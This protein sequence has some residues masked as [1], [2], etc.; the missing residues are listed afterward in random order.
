MNLFPDDEIARRLSKSTRHLSE[1][2]I[3]EDVEL[4]EM[5]V[6]AVVHGHCHHEA[7]L[8]F[9][10]YGEVLGKMKVD[11]EVLDDGCCGLAGS[12]GYQE[13]NYDISEKC[14]K[15]K[16]IPAVEEADSDTVILS[17]GYSCREQ[18]MQFSDRKAITLPELILKGFT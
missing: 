2:L 7:V 1:F 17:D 6:K 15:R 11:F 12:F 10:K 5:A 4:P 9:E 16:L 18:I 14:A 8:D 13:S 3:D